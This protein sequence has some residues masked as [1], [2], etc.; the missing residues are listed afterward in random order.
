MIALS[1]QLRASDAHQDEMV[2]TDDLLFLLALFGRDAPA[3]VR[4][5]AH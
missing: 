5:P 4:Y 1:L 3:D 2:G